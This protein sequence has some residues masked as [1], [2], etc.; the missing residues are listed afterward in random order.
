MKRL[1]KGAFFTKMTIPW[2]LQERFSL[3][4]FYL[5][6]AYK[7]HYTEKQSFADVLQNGILKNFAS[8]TGKHF[9]GVSF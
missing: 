3:K 9:V 4:M 7:Y 1:F 5:H 6:Y 2:Q 8:F